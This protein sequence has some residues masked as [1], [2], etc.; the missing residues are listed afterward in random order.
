[1]VLELFL[2]HGFLQLALVAS[3]LMALLAGALGVPLVLREMSMFGHGFAHVS[4]AGIA[5]GL[6]AGLYPLGTALLVTALAAVGIEWLR[7]AGKLKG[8]TSLAIVVSVGFAA[9]VVLVGLA[10]GFSADIGA[11]LFG[12]PFTVSVQDVYLMV[13]LGVLILGSFALLYKEILFVTFDEEGAR[14]A[15][16]PVSSINVVLVVLTAGTIVMGIRVVGLLLVASLLVIPAATA[17]Q[18]SQSF[19]GA[20]AGSM[21]VSL[22]SAVVGLALAVGYDLASGGTIVLTAAAMFGVVAGARRAGWI[23]GPA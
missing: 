5:L 4:Y 3:S 12:S 6:F 16:V 10:G 7:S 15:G 8:D 18:V 11:Y 21:A 2:E 9:G 1:M 17:L 22:V 23:E 14:L 20:I 13:P 19:K